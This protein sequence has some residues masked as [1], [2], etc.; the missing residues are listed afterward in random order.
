M[1]LDIGL[2]AYQSIPPGPRVLAGLFQGLAARASGFSIVPIASLAPALQFLYVVMMYIAV[3]P[4]ALSIRSTNVY[5][6]R[7]LGVFE[8]PDEDDDEEPT[9]IGKLKTR[10][11]RIGRYVGWH[12][13][14]QMSIGS[15]A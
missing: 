14:K 1:N 8:E 7:S 4:V 15:F 6:E 10:R 3:Y 12:W 2:P 9:D 13:R 5:E 11:E